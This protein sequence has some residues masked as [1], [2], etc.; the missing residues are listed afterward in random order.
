MRIITDSILD[1]EPTAPAPSSSPPSSTSEPSPIESE[2]D[3][4]GAEDEEEEG[5]GGVTLL[6]TGCGAPALFCG[7]VPTFFERRASDS[8]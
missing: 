7:Y 6:D 5:V 2:D 3:S 8:T 4:D 1:I